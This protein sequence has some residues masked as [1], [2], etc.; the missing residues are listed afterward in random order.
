MIELKKQNDSH[1]EILLE[2]SFDFEN[3]G[4]FRFYV[5]KIIEANAQYLSINFKEVEYID[6]SALGMLMLAKHETDQHNCKLELS[7][8]KD[9]HAKDVLH[10]VKFNQLFTICES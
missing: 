5:K 1:Y 8:V 2:K 3:H 10:L 9:G 4:D 7:N 6:S